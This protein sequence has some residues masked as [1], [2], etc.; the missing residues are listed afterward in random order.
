MTSRHPTTH[1]APRRRF[2]SLDA[3]EA[4]QALVGPAEAEGAVYDPAAVELVLEVTRGYLYF[5]QELG[6]QV[7]TIATANRIY[8]EDV[9]MAQE[10]YDT[11]LDSSFFRAPRQGHALQ[12]ANMRAIAQLGPEPQKAADVAHLLDRES[13]QVG[14]TRAELIEMGMLY[15]PEHTATQ[16]SQFPTSTSS[17]CTQYQSSPYPG[18]RTASAENIRVGQAFPALRVCACAG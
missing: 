4:R 5:I 13:S 16:P 11:K 10:A 7:G 2:G 1:Q 8:R 15:T 18:S 17:C 14:P 9:L 6:Y 12:T 3:S